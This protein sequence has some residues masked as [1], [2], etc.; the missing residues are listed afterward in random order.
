MILLALLL[1][2]TPTPEAEALGRRLAATG[3]L[4]AILPM[5]I[6]KDTEELV[7]AHPEL[8]APEQADLR[9]TAATVARAGTERL[10]AA[11]GHEYASSLSVD[12]LKAL[13]AY[14]ESPVA[15]RYRAAIPA[16]TAQAMQAAGKFDFKADVAK[17]FCAKTKK[18]CK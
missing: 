16:A 17:A 9:A 6:K 7:A 1:A 18:L 13:V 10:N 5:M 15:K 14:N 11:M 4:A 2:A 3:T 8:S 12:D